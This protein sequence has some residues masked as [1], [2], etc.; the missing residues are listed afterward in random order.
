MKNVLNR[1]EF[2]GFEN[3]RTGEDVIAAFEDLLGRWLTLR[4]LNEVAE[5][6]YTL[7]EETEEY[8]RIARIGLSKPRRSKR[9]RR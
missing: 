7:A 9:R 1:F 8:V 5:H 4:E 6:Y 2:K 3:L